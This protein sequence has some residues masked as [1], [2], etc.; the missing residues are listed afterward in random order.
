M[1]K[2][3][4]PLVLYDSDCGLC[5]R[6]VQFVL[7]RDNGGRFFF[8]PLDGE[9]A[10]GVLKELPSNVNSVVLI[11]GPGQSPLIRSRAVFGILRELGGAWSILACLDYLPSWLFD[12]A[13]RLVARYRR[14]LFSLKPSCL[15]PTEEQRTRF[16]P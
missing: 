11:R 6:S 16:L 2:Q 5:Q 8:A 7:R 3:K 15:V 12:W 1:E 10:A 9:T 4:F 13:Y 14:R